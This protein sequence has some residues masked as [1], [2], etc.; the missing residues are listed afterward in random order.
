MSDEDHT[1]EE[2]SLDEKLAQSLAGTENISESIWNAHRLTNGLIGSQKAAGLANYIATH[3]TRYPTSRTLFLILEDDPEEVVNWVEAYIHGE[4][5]FTRTCPLQPRHGVLESTRCDTSREA[6]IETVETLQAVMREKDPKG[7]LMVQPFVNCVGSAVLAPNMYVAIGEGHDGIT[8]GCDFS[9]ALP[10]NPK[11]NHFKYVLSNMSE[12]SGHDYDPKLHEIELVFDI[13][14]V[15]DESEKYVDTTNLHNFRSSLYEQCS[16][17]LTQIRGCDEHIS[18]CPPPAGVSING[19]IPSGT[20]VAT[21]VWVMSGLEKVIWLEENITKETVPEGFV[22]SEPNGS[23][24]SHICAHCRTHGIPY[25][26]GEVSEG[27]TWTEAAGGWVVENS[28]G[29]FEA[30]PYN[31]FDYIEMFRSGIMY[32]NT[33]WR[34][35]HAYF[36]T[37]FHQWMGQ[38]INDPAFTAFLAGIFAAWMVKAAIGACVGEMRHASSQKRNRLPDCGLFINS[39]IGDKVINKHSSNLSPMG[40]RS[41]YHSWMTETVIDW[42]GAAA[43]LSLCEKLFNTGW[44]SSYGGK[45]WGSG[46][47]AGAKVAALIAEMCD[48]DMADDAYLSDTLGPALVSAVNELENAQHNNGNLLNKF[49]SDIQLAYTYGTEG[50]NEENLQAAFL[51]YVMARDVHNDELE[52]A[53]LP[54]QND[55]L[56]ACEW[57][58]SKSAK[59]WRTNPL[60]STAW[61][62]T[63]MPEEIIEVVDVYRNQF[64]S[65]S[66][67]WSHAIST[68][69]YS[70]AGEASFVPCNHPM[71]QKCSHHNKLSELP[72]ELSSI[73]TPKEQ[74]MDVWK[75]EDGDSIVAIIK[76]RII[77]TLRAMAAQ[78]EAVTIEQVVDAYAKT[79]EKDCV[80]AAEKHL[81]QILYQFNV[82][83][84]V[85]IMKA[86]AQVK[87]A[88]A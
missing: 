88:Q 34:R 84:F 17:T 18:V 56:T 26:I 24:L 5:I 14:N 42:E 49:G 66:A 46:A 27:E 67:T 33:H 51:T 4:D 41:P 38:P 35:K 83:D 79:V 3:G 87:E 60:Y 70:L 76:P 45:K 15:W 75:M 55:W 64:S 44:S 61:S 52:A 47:A 39:V 63:D 8:A 22:V 6:I 77:N 11:G 20:V 74:G 12:D 53:T 29:L 1:E 54:P 16:V 36:S 2:P 28:D 30:Q 68:H 69:T 10:L 31:P 82:T 48:E 9:M 72:M 59:F 19:A 21:E 80:E 23:L 62:E 81:G 58:S 71:C 7:C 86:I 40:S 50:F 73:G 78:G 65:W 13:N 43:V 32:G 85:T 25:V 57:L 37:F